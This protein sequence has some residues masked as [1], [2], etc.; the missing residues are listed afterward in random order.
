MLLEKI[1]QNASLLAK[2]PAY[3]CGEDSLTYS[4]LWN[5][6]SLLAAQLQDGAGAVALIGT[7]QPMMAVGMLGSLLAGRPY[8][9]LSSDQPKERLQRIL[10]QAN[11]GTVIDC[12]EAKAEQWLKREPATQNFLIPGDPSRDAYWLFTSGSSGSPKGVRISLAALENFV[13][14]FCA[15]PAI[16]FRKEPGVALNQAQFSFDLSVADLW[17]AWMMGETVFALEPSQQA[18]LD[19]LYR[20]LGESGAT[21]MSCT[22]SFA[23]LCLCD[24]SFQRELMPALQ[25][26]FFCGETLPART[27]RQLRQRFPGVTVLNAYGPTEATCAV[28]AVE[29]TGAGE[30]LPVGQLENTA[31]QLLILDRDGNELPPG[32]SGEIAIAGQSVASGYLNASAERF[33]SWQGQ[34]LYRTGDIGRIENGLLWYSGRLDRQLKYKGYRIEPGEIEAVIRSWPQVQAAAVLPMTAGDQVVALA[35]VVEW[36]EPPPKTADCDAQLRKSLPAYM[37]PKVWLPVE[38]MPVNQ[39][40][41]CDLQ[42][43]KEMLQN[44]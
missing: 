31:C 42:A 2:H 40:G 41:K 34:R 9:P 21:R 22:P 8:L 35:A 7:K 32:Q 33:G 17:P 13:R 28:C 16:R 4:Q 12:R 10:S 26:V 23:R 20:A 25:T 38:R 6:A 18:D 27:V 43:L 5:A 1:Q 19:K 37:L 36:I 44:G 3:R 14:W 39:N 11:P 29:V 30:P 15:L 24:K